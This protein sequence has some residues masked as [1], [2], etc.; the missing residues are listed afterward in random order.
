[1][2]RE[3]GGGEERGGGK[4][5]VCVC[6]RGL[7][8]DTTVSTCIKFFLENESSMKRSAFKS[9]LLDVA[10]ASSGRDQIEFESFNQ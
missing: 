10:S 3:R 1:M 8:N 6:V 4:E 7:I 5:G 9:Y 2:H